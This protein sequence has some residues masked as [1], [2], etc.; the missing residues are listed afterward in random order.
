[1]AIDVELEI[2]APPA[3]RWIGISTLYVLGILLVTLAI[4]RTPEDMG[5]TVFLLVM[6]VV[7][8]WFAE[9]TRQATAH[10]LRLTPE[11]LWETGGRRIV[12]L[13]DVQEVDRGL[14]A[15]KPSNGFLIVT[16]S[17]Q[18]NAWRPGLYWIIGRR[19]GVGGVVSRAQSKM[20]ADTMSMMI[21]ERK[22]GGKT[23][24]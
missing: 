6:G 17:V 5:W 8:L 24:K 4:F 16:E 9:K 12:A 18:D 21:A 10:G 15:F 13:D 7:S 2:Y 1:M 14:F 23:R 11:G 19:I 20:M 22:E 3:R